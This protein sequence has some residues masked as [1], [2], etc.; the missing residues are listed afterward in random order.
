MLG[1]EALGGPS[2]FCEFS[3]GI[4]AMALRNVRSEGQRGDLHILSKLAYRRTY[5]DQM[6]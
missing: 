5:S 2:S 1:D 4:R 6:V 3:V